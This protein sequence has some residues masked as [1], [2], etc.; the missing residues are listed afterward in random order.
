MA[1]L[2]SLFCHTTTPPVIPTLS[3]HDALPISPAG[4]GV[5]TALVAAAVRAAAATGTLALLVVV[6][7]TPAL[8]IDGRTARTAARLVDLAVHRAVA[9]RCPG[10]PCPRP[11]RGEPGRAPVRSL[12]LVASRPPGEP[13]ERERPW[14]T[15][16]AYSSISTG[17]SRTAA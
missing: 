15:A 3:L 4:L 1:R 16:A 10:P 14:Q 17:P 5:E 13:G 8:D 12:T 7:L 6:E 2:L 9:L 11:H